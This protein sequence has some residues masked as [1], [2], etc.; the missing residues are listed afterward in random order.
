MEKR[1][2]RDAVNVLRVVTEYSQREMKAL[3][4]WVVTKVG[5]LQILET[6][7]VERM[8]EDTDKNNSQV[9]GIKKKMEQYQY[10]HLEMP[11]LTYLSDN[12]G[13]HQTDKWM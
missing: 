9:F 7:D 8:G 3:S 5:K 2:A 6:R 13:S 4:S 10:V 1:I 12:K 11:T